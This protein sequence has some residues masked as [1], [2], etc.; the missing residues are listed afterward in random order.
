MHIRKNIADFLE[1]MPKVMKM[2]KNFLK[3]GCFLLVN[4]FINMQAKIFL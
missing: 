4:R 2:P 1:K 3:M